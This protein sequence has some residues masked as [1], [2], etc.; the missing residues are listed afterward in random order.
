[1]EVAHL[2]LSE[3]ARVDAGRLEH[4]VQEYGHSGAERLIGQLLEEIAVRLNRTERAWTAG[5]TERVLEGA[6]AL[7]DIADGIGLM[8]LSKCARAAAGVAPTGDYAALGAT[9]ARMIRVGES[10]L[11]SAWDLQNMSI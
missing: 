7:A 9:V 8:S 2:D 4:L 5:D 6:R 11:M 10:S 3:M 1:M